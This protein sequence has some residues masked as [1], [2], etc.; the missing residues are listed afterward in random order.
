MLTALNT[1]FG[2]DR[3]LLLFAFIDSFNQ[4]AELCKPLCLVC[5]CQAG[6]YK[7][8]QTWGVWVQANAEKP[9]VKAHYPEHHCDWK[10]LTSL[11]PAVAGVAQTPLEWQ[12]F[13]LSVSPHSRGQSVISCGSHTDHFG[14]ACLE[15]RLRGGNK[16]LPHSCRSKVKYMPLAFKSL[17]VEISSRHQIGYNCIYG[18]WTNVL[19][20]SCLLR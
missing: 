11:A 18:K 5:Q 13:F 16:T 3:C 8:R 6:H 1:A 15:I 4:L 7:C 19:L 12:R 10:T 14:F 9:C 17:V 2:K 20:N